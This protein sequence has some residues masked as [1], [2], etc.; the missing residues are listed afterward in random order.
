MGYRLGDVATVDF[1]THNPFTGNISDTDVP[2]TCDVFENANDLPIL[3]P[4]VVR[5]FGFVGVYRVS[6]VIAASTGFE[7]GK[8]YNVVVTAQV[9]GV[10][11]RAVILAFNIEVPLPLDDATLKRIARAVRG[12]VLRGV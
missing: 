6:F 3:T 10:T 7:V 1:T 5:R 2:P 12:E 8:S 11:A 9:A 4:P